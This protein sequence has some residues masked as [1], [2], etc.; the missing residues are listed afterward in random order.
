MLRTQGASRQGPALADL[1]Q[2]HLLTVQISIKAC[3]V[4]A[5]TLRLRLPCIIPIDS[6]FR[7]RVLQIIRVDCASALR[8][9]DHHSGPLGS[10]VEEHIGMSEL[11]AYVQVTAVKAVFFEL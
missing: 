2:T 5:Q 6:Y 10:R 9:C 7:R 1:V 3:R 8:A 4:Q 11:T